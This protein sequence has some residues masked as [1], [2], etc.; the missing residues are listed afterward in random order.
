MSWEKLAESDGHIVEIIVRHDD[1]ILVTIDGVKVKRLVD[2]HYSRH[3]IDGVPQMVI[4]FIPETISVV[5]EDSNG[6]QT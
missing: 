5:T 3:S 4:T 2:I 6:L 1:T